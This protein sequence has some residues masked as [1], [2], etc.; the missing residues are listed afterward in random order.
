MIRI[1]I[2]AIIYLISFLTQAQGNSNKENL[3][4]GESSFTI[5]TTVSQMNNDKGTVH[6]AQF[7]S[8]EGFDD[9]RHFQAR[10][11]KAD[12]NGVAVSFEDITDGVNSITCFHDE[13]DNGKMDFDSNSR[14]MEDYGSSNNVQGFGP[15]RFSNAK[16]VV[17]DK[18]LT[19]EI[20]F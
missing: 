10:S 20:R 16:F 9:R 11:V 12:K 4:D 5:K 2:T 18:D 13:N 6:F 1:F 7:S 14:P 15:P 8:E 3:L 19:F 17:N